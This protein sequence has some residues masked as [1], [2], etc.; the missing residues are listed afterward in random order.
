[1]FDPILDRLRS[2]ENQMIKM[3]Q[4]YKANRIR[5]Y[6]TITINDVI[7]SNAT[8][9]GLLSMTSKN[10]QSLANSAAT[11]VTMI[12]LNRS[13]IYLN[14]N[15][16]V[17]KVNNETL[18]YALKLNVCMPGYELHKNGYLCGKFLFLNNT[19]LFYFKL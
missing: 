5:L 13:N 14:N 11:L 3:V 16:T 15:R 12:L 8:S 10:R 1:M 18:T 6:F 4:E 17:L 7:P 9:T 19:F 2:A